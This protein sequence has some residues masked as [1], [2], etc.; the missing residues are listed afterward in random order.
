MKPVSFRWTASAGR[1]IP[2]ATYVMIGRRWQTAS[3]SF[4][5]CAV[6]VLLLLAAAAATL[7]A[8]DLAAALAVLAAATTAIDAVTDA[9]AGRSA[10]AIELV[11]SIRLKK[12][13]LNIIIERN[14]SSLIVKK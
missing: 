11:N 3:T 8:A 13:V 10:V 12:N 5:R 7:A 4:S 1:R 9:A 14:I 6:S 2:R